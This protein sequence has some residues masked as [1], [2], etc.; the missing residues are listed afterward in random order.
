MSPLKSAHRP[1]GGVPI[2]A[3]MLAYLATRR[4][5]AFFATY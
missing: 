5:R 4:V 1:R 3:L 2:A